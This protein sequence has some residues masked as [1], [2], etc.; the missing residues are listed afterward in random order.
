MSWLCILI[1]T[2]QKLATI[3][4]LSTRTV[5]ILIEQWNVIRWVLQEFSLNG[6]ICLDHSPQLQELEFLGEIVKL[7][8]ECI[9]QWCGMDHD[10]MAGLSLGAPQMVECVVVLL[11]VVMQV[12]C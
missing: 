4:E 5:I 9:L 1:L 11:A 2:A 3:W 6:I 10:P 12:T 8:Q 7:R